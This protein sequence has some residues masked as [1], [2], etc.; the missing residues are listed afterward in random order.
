[1][2]SIKS[3]FDEIS[4]EPSTNKKMDILTKY[5]N[6]ET[7]VR[8]LYLA[9]S[10][11][12]KF[13]IKQ[14]PEYTNPRGEM[15]LDSALDALSELSSRKITGNS[16]VGFLYHLLTSLTPDDAYIIE[17]II[18][19]DCKIGMGSTQMNKVIPN[20]IE[21]T[22]YMG[23]KSYDSK[24]ILKLF[25]GDVKVKKGA[26][27]P[28]PV[29]INEC[30]SDVKAD[31]RYVNIDIS[32][33]EVEMV[34]RAGEE[35]LIGD[36][37][38]LKELENYPDCVLNGELV[39]EGEKRETSN[40]LI[41]SIIDI[42][43]KLR[44]DDP[45]ENE[46]GQLSI[47]N[48]F[49]RHGLV[50][51]ELLNRV[52]VIVWDILDRDDYFT[53]VNTVPRIDRLNRL[54]K[55]VTESNSTMISVVEYKFVNSPE[56]AYEHFA[57]MLDRGEEGTILKSMDGVWKD[58]KPNY[59]LKMKIEFDMDLIITGFNYGN[60]GTKNE[61][62]ISSVT[63]ETSCGKL[64][65]KA[66]GIPED[67]MQHITDNQNNLMGTIVK[68]KCNGLSN[69][70]NGGYSVQYPTLMELR[71]DKSVANSY[72]ECVEIENMVKSLK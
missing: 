51:S 10:K 16:A 24:L 18:E 48:I 52:K 23:A 72:D 21:K 59:Q 4:A 42:T 32:G 45:K 15:G 58:G 36:A 64:I 2:S 22:P 38:L 53:N 56:Q 25:T 63:C 65:C 39:I 33:G 5:K 6:N 30:I 12:V 29:Y 57:E 11:R 60:K 49:K 62:V 55:T 66:Q 46:K 70:R 34:S 31:G 54:I 71:D 69:N 17:R 19:K 27:V 14:I 8:V 35:T 37:L 47:D 7:L 9:K 44:S 67:L 41:T 68:V 43:Q 20:L 40:G 26:V 61:D 3:I 1:M 13:Y 28:E 50:Y